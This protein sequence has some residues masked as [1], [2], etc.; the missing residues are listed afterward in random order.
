MICID[1][2]FQGWEGIVRLRLSRERRCFGGWK[3]LWHMTFA[4]AWGFQKPM[5][6]IA[7]HVKE[8]HGDDLDY[9]ASA[10]CIMIIKGRPR[11]ARHAQYTVSDQADFVNNNHK[12]FHKS[13]RL[14]S[15]S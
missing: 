6:S 13:K 11:W 12:T 1:P 3:G 8:L 15:N 7:L 9:P 14:Q 4:S 2:E 10:L 5:V